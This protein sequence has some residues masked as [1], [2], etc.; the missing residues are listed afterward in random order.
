MALELRIEKVTELPAAAS[1]TEST[2]Y[3]VSNLA[4]G[5][6]IDVYVTSSDALTIKKFVSSSDVSSMIASSLQSFSS[7][8]VVNTIT[9]RNALVTGAPGNGFNTSMPSQVMVI[10]AT[11]DPTVTTGGATYI[12]ESVS[13]TWFKISE[14]ESLDLVL[15]WSSLVGGPASSVADIDDA[16]SKKHTHTNKTTLDAISTIN[17][18]LAYNGTPVRAYLDAEAW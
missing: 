2:M 14:Y 8:R 3:L 12:W 7:I 15:N 18:K 5:D 11:G 17:N 16:V 13:Q 1:W 6:Y 10:T 4:L 9:E